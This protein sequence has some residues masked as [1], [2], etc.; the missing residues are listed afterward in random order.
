MTLP[1]FPR[2]AH[3]AVLLATIAA[4]AGSAHLTAQTVAIVDVAVVDVATG[5]VLPTHTVV[6]REGVI[7][8]IEAADSATLSADVAWIDGEGLFLVPGRVESS[9]ASSAMSATEWWEVAF[10][11]LA[12]G[13]T[14]LEVHGSGEAELD[15]IR[16]TWRPSD[17]APRLV[18]GESVGAATNP[19][20]RPKIEV[21]APAE[22]L[23]MEADPRSNSESDSTPLAVLIGSRVFPRADLEAWAVREAK[24]RRA[25]QYRSVPLVRMP[26]MGSWPRECV[27]KSLEECFG[28]DPECGLFHELFTVSASYRPC[29]DPS[30]PEARAA[31]LGSLDRLAVAAP[32][33]AWIVGQ[34][35]YMALVDGDVDR[36]WSA[37]DDCASDLWWCQSLRGLVLHTSDPGG[38]AG[39]VFDSAYASAPPGT[40]AWHPLAWHPKDSVDAGDR[41]L[42]C[43]WRDLYYLIAME[44]R[45]L[46]ADYT[47]T[48]CGTASPLE[49]RF[50]FLTDPF[51]SD[52]GNARR[53]EHVARNV[54]ARLR[55][56]VLRSS[57]TSGTPFH[58]HC[59]VPA[60]PAGHLAGGPGERASPHCVSSHGELIATGPHNS[61][62]GVR[63]YD[64]I[65]FPISPKGTLAQTD[66]IPDDMY[67]RKDWWDNGSWKD[68]CFHIPDGLGVA[69]RCLGRRYDQY[70]LGFLHGG[71]S[72]VPDGGRFY[73][74][75]SSTAADWALTWNEG[76][77]RMLT[78]YA[79]HNLD[80]QVAVLRRGEELQILSA[81][82]FPT[83]L[84]SLDFLEAFLAVGRADDQRVEVATASVDRASG[85][86][87]AEI[88]LPDDGWIASVEALAPEVRGRA[89]LGAPAPPLTD[90]FGISRPVVLPAE[91]RPG[92]DDLLSSMLPDTRVPAAGD[93]GLYIELY[94]VE[95][96]QTAEMTLTYDPAELET[97]LLRRLTGA[98]GIGRAGED[99]DPVRIEWSEQL[100]DVEAGIGRVFVSA[101]LGDFD[102]VELEL[103]VG[104]AVGGRSADS[105][106]RLRPSR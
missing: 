65:G 45:A 20:P 12:G 40:P 13:V 16:A 25:R 76:H 22:L 58:A 18:V 62:R 21:G 71:Y 2:A 80:H 79:W 78:R 50:W 8:S 73:R 17:P 19:M 26:R 103:T 91:F 59:A 30:L 35:V 74:P 97:G 85:V 101:D 64:D 53:D 56:D 67:R 5:V 7:A 33:D 27:G 61:W 15:S 75:E 34:R 23:L 72:F 60:D 9:R 82:V 86:M 54:L 94:G 96:G 83:L 29:T 70:R 44:E 105:T 48:E 87:R 77:E 98:V 11:K 47:S 39:V 95:A 63:Y 49:A 88:R 10:A 1:P 4:T 37:A 46:L 52:V 68:E 41:G 100:E 90:G 102:D 31:V 28:R 42:H 106:L 38:R 51:W 55:D 32:G 89:R 92:T 24:A 43:E 14:T 84:P 93:I 66:G 81:S 3:T 69:S 36:A 57:G 104:A 6:I 99:Q